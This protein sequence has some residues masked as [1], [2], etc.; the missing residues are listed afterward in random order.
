MPHEQPGL[1][2]RLLV[3]D[4]RFVGAPSA[5]DLGAVGMDFSA[6]DD[7]LKGLDLGGEVFDV[8]GVGLELAGEGGGDLKGVH[9][10][11]GYGGGGDDVLCGGDGVWCLV[12]MRA[13]QW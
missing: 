11:G 10:C 7:E 9:F 5:G 2:L 6:F 3:V 4:G 8:V 12:G 13:G 1:I